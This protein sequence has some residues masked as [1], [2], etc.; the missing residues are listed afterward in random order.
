MMKTQLFIKKAPT[1]LKALA[2]GMSAT[3][4]VLTCFDFS[5]TALL[6]IGIVAISLRIIAWG[7]QTADRRGWIC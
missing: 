5:G 6:V 7:I 1:V 4:K 3:N 2:T